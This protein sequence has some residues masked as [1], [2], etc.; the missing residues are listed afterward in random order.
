MLNGGI[1]SISSMICISISISSYAHMLIFSSAVSWVSATTSASASAASSLSAVAA[2]VSESV[3]SHLCTCSSAI[4]LTSASS[5]SASA[6]QSISASYVKFYC[7]NLCKGRNVKIVHPKSVLCGSIIAAIPFIKDMA[8]PSGNNAHILF[9]F[10]SVLNESVP[11]SPTNHDKNTNT[12]DVGCCETS[13]DNGDSM[14][15]VII[16]A[17]CTNRRMYLESGSEILKVGFLDRDW[18]TSHPPTHI[19]AV[20]S[21]YRILLQIWKPLEVEKIRVSTFAHE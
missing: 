19:A 5:A 17:Q 21:M 2:S 18:N 16:P 7:L 13:L 1:I 4:S 20:Y 10:K 8:R 14:N 11:K 12:Q 6:S 15:W 9:S 3:F